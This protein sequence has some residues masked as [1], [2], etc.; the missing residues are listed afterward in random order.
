MRDNGETEGALAEKVHGRLSRP[1]QAVKSDFEEGGDFEEFV[2]IR[3]L[4]LNS[5]PCSLY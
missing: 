3:H 5:L 1:A 2:H 4:L